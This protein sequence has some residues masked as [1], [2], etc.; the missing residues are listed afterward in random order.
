M[1][2]GILCHTVNPEVPILCPDCLI[3]QFDTLSE[4]DLY[5]MYNFFI[6]DKNVDESIKEIFFVAF[7]KLMLYKRELDEK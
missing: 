1:C 2:Y 4:E 3:E 5:E 7:N 6:N